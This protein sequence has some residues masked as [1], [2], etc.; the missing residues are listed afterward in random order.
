VEREG[1]TDLGDG[2]GVTLF[3]E[4]VVLEA[5]IVGISIAPSGLAVYRWQATG[6]G[7]GGT[8]G[9]GRFHLLT[10]AGGVRL[11]RLLLGRDDLGHPDVVL[12]PAVEADKVVGG[13]DLLP[14][15]E[16]GRGG[17]EEKMFTSGIEA[18]ELDHDKS[19]SFRA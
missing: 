3:T 2:G 14:G 16:F 5:A 11:R 9:I 7:S 19:R 15:Y 8:D 1:G 4:L 13:D 17:T 18:I 6:I 10:V 12:G